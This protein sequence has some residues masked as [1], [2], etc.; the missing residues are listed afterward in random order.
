VGRERVGLATLTKISG[1]VTN[2]SEN[3]TFI[4]CGLCH[5]RMARSKTSSFWLTEAVVIAA[6]TQQGTG[7]ID[8]GAYV[9]VGDQQG[10]AVEE[11]DFIWQDLDTATGEYSAALGGTVG[12]N[13]AFDG[14]LGDLNPAGLIL[15]ADDNQL[16]ASGSMNIDD[17]NNVLSFGP[18]LYPDSFGTLSEARMVVNDQLY[19]VATSSTPV[20]ANHSLILVV[21]IKC[22][23]VKLTTK[24][25]MAI[26]IQSTAADN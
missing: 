19:V 10:I 12:A 25:W 8:L 5:P 18:D 14:Q 7:T 1:D 4:D 13:A 22:R 9:D 3:I 15:R 24:D 26:A 2:R 17:T 11:V 16:I 20:L 6:T 21:R 23:V